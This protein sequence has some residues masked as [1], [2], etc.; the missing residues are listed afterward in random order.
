MASQHK[1]RIAISLSISL[2]CVYAFSLGEERFMDIFHLNMQAWCIS[3]ETASASNPKQHKNEKLPG[4]R[5]TLN[6]CKLH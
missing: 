3:R 6:V 5:G 4:A 1:G 2:A